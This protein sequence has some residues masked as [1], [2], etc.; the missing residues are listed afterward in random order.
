[1]MRSGLYQIIISERIR[2]DAYA[3]G[4]MAH[5]HFSLS[6]HSESIASRS[7]FENVLRLISSIYNI[8]GRAYFVHAS[9]YSDSK[10]GEAFVFHMIL[11]PF[12]FIQ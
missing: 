3:V 1:M 4:R 5:A 9:I 11:Y 6:A 8:R 7:Q 10:T 12:L 2:G